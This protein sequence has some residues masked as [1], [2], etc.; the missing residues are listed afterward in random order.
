MNI[1]I[2]KCGDA[3][4]DFSWTDKLDSVD[5]AVLITS[6]ITQPFIDAVM[7]AHR[8][9]HKLMIHAVCSGWGGFRSLE[10]E[11]PPYGEQLK[12]LDNLLKQG[13]PVQQCVLRI[14]PIFPTHDGLTAVRNVLDMAYHEGIL[15]LMRVRISVFKDS[16][17]ESIQGQYA[18]V[19]DLIYKN[20]TSPSK[21]QYEAVRKAL[22]HYDLQFHTCPDP[23]LTDESG[24]FVYTEEISAIDLRMLGIDAQEFENGQF[25]QTELLKNRD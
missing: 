10:P 23:L 7:Q 9:G 25:C 21:E 15:P 4:Q 8:Q 5:C 14:E 2:T 20:Q 12:S 18:G 19:G 24:L 22:Y 6:N 11:N 1:G 13:F 17:Q 3:S 16:H